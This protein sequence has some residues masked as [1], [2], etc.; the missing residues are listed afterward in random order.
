MS[1]QRCLVHRG[2]RVEEP[3]GVGQPLFGP[4]PFVAVVFGAEVDAAAVAM[5]FGAGDAVGDAAALGAVAIVGV[6]VGHVVGAELVHKTDRIGV[7]A[8]DPGVLAG[9]EE[10]EGIFI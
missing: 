1:I 10:G 5:V 7:A 8:Q 2:D 4:A 3:G 9:G 6:H